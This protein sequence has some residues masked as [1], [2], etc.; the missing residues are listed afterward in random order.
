MTTR[1]LAAYRSGGDGCSE[2][3]LDETAKTLQLGETIFH[4]GDVLTLD[5]NNGEVY[6]GA[7]RT[8]TEP[9]VELCA[10]LERLRLR[11]EPPAGLARHRRAPHAAR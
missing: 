4:K 8:E 9:M 6:A 11:S 3:R 1:W 5:G 7:V 2:L 10:R